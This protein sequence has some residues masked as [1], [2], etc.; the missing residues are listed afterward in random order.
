MQASH[1]YSKDDRTTVWSN[2]NEHIKPAIQAVTQDQEDI[3]SSG[4]RQVVRHVP[5]VKSG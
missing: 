3:L 1:A 2:V 4:L 5:W